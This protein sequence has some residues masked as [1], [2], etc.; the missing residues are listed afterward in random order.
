MLIFFNLLDKAIRKSPQASGETKG[1]QKPA[2]NS[3]KKTH[4]NSSEDTEA[5][6]N[7]KSR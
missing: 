7:D 5:K 6:Q 1:F 4:R 2:E 3:D